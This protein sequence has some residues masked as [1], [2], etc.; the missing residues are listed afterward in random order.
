MESQLILTLLLFFS[1]PAFGSQVCSSNK[2]VMITDAFVDL[3]VTDPTSTIIPFQPVLATSDGGAVYGSLR[4]ANTGP[5][6]VKVDSNA[7][8]EWYKESRAA[9]ET[10][11]TY[12]YYP[13]EI[14]EEVADSDSTLYYVYVAG[15]VTTLFDH[16]TPVWGFVM[17]YS[18]WDGSLLNSLIMK[19]SDSSCIYTLMLDS[20][21]NIFFGGYSYVSATSTYSAWLARVTDKSTLSISDQIVSSGIATPTRVFRVFEDTSASTYVLAGGLGTTAY[22]WV[23]GF[24]SS[25]WTRSWEY[26]CP[27]CVLPIVYTLLKTSTAT[28]TYALLASQVFYTVTKSGGISAGVA[29]SGSYSM[30][31]SPTDPAMLMIFGYDTTPSSFAYYY[32]PVSNTQYTSGLTA[33]NSGIEFHSA[34]FNPSYP[35]VWVSA[36]F[37]SSAA[38]RKISIFKLECVTPLSCTSPALNYRNKACYAPSTTG[39]FGL[40]ATCLIAGNINGCDTVTSIAIPAA[41]SIFVGGCPGG[42]TYYRASSSGCVGVMQ[43]SSCHILCG[44]ECLA[45]SDATKCAQHCQ[46]AQLEPYIDDSDLYLNTCKC[47]GS[48]TVSTVSSRCVFTSG[49]YPLCA[50]SECGELSDNT[51]CIGCI[52]GAHIVSTT[53]RLWTTCACADGY[54]LSGTSCLACHPFCQNCTAPGDNNQCTACVASLPN[55]EM[56]GTSA[57]SCASQTVYDSGLCVF[58]TGCHALCAGECTVQADAGACAFSCVQTAAATVTGTT[59][60]FVCAC[61][62]ET[63]FNGT[64]CAEIVNSDCQPLCEGGCLEDHGYECVACKDQINVVARLASGT[65]Y[66]TCTCASGTELVGAVC[67]YQTNCSSHCNGTCLLQNNASACLGCA[68]GI[69]PGEAATGDLSVICG[70]PSG[71]VYSGQTCAAVL[72]TNCSWMCGGG[73]CTAEDDPLACIGSCADKSNVVVKSK[74]SEI[75]TCGCANG[76]RLSSSGSDCILNITCDP[77]CESCLDSDTCLVCQAGEGMVVSSGQCICETSQG[78]LMVTDQVTGASSCIQPSTG[79]ASAIK[80]SGYHH[81]CSPSGREI[82]VLTLII[83]SAAFSGSG[84]IAIMIVTHRSSNLEVSQPDTGAAASLGGKCEVRVAGPDLA[85]PGTQLRRPRHI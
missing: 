18:R 85:F 5:R 25:A 77:L 53:A 75:V 24:A 49:C 23:A 43:S 65:N 14:V 11:I 38:G 84:C 47:Q 74:A 17:K 54:A 41:A 64:A 44:M 70:C 28:D 81:V 57:C 16:N 79:T 63:Q 48:R 9:E 52:S 46:G 15:Y 62:V 66:Y 55:V 51:K 20:R 80:Y 33:H 83:A 2:D 37:P 35:R 82:I 30:T 8:F 78:Y 36:F 19:K 4:S 68:A 71:T 56:T 21:G 3:Y 12:R 29:L 72:S 67:A 27:S 76:T 58:T 31:I 59:G 1:A 10:S 73:N 42:G 61:P 34:G 39:C 22:L 6:I 13:R 50:N 7:N 40:C 32:D 45:V 26:V 69:I 60:I